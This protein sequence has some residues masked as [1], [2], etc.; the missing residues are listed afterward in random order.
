MILQIPYSIFYLLKG[1]YRVWAACDKDEEEA[2]RKDSVLLAF[3]L[4]SRKLM[5]FKQK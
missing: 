2:C 4:C 5:R 3:F 1:D